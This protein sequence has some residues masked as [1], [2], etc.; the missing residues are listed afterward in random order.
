MK[1]AKSGDVGGA[2]HIFRDINFGEFGAVDVRALRVQL[3]TISG[4]L[5]YQA[6]VQM[7]RGV[8]V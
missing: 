1:P 7:G 3:A 8:R 6:R 2:G 5:E 4:V